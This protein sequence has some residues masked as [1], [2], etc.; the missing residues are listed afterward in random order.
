MK[1]KYITVKI[2]GFSCFGRQM[3][4]DIFK[5][6][7]SVHILLTVVQSLLFLK[8]YFAFSFYGTKYSFLKHHNFATT[9]QIF[10]LLVAC[11][12]Y[13]SEMVFMNRRASLL[14]DHQLNVI[15]RR[16]EKTQPNK[17]S[18]CY[19]ISSS[20]SKLRCLYNCWIQL[21]FR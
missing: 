21:E 5:Q 7:H 6:K 11:V 8:L 19:L 4:K 15:T 16:D 14:H 3:S 20:C 17:L 1:I 2:L 18:A 12:F 9:I 10:I 13:F